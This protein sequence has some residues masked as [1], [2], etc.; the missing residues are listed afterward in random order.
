MRRVYELVHRVLGE[1][2]SAAEH[3]SWAHFDKGT[4]AYHG[5][6]EIQ[7]LIHLSDTKL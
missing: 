5:C 6:Y 2:S 4:L 7:R 1:E 3:L